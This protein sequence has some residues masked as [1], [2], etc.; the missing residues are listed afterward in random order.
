[1]KKLVIILLILAALAALYWYVIRPWMA[2]RQVYKGPAA[3]S[4]PSQVA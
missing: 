2:K 3:V 4:T 1:M